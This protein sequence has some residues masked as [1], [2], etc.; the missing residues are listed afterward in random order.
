MP[1]SIPCRL[2]TVLAAYW[3][4][5]FSTTTGDRYDQGMVILVDCNIGRSVRNHLN[6]YSRYRGGIV[7]Y[8][9]MYVLIAISYYFLS[10]AAKSIPI[11]IAYAVWEGLGIGMITVV[12]MFV[13]GSSLVTQELIGLGMVLFGLV[14]VTA[15]EEHQAHNKEP[16][17]QC[18]F[19]RENKSWLGAA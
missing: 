6:E 10:L 7:G 9:A 3:L 16:D 15:G 4:A 13:F 11:G 19:T 5:C 18:E 14:L 17:V 1:G 8:L 12:S 2:L